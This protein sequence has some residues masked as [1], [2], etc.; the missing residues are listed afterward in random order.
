MKILEDVNFLA[1]YRDFNHLTIQLG[2]RA[3]KYIIMTSR[4]FIN[5][6]MSCFLI[7]TTHKIDLIH[8]RQGQVMLLWM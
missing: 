3:G 1:N 8:T 5:S 6:L 4:L 7:A 2:A